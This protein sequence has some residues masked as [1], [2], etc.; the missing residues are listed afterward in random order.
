[1]QLVAAHL[2]PILELLPVHPIPARAEAALSMAARVGIGTECCMLG[3][4]VESEKKVPSVSC[5][6]HCVMMY[7]LCEV[8]ARIMS[9]DTYYCFIRSNSSPAPPTLFRTAAD[10]MP[11]SS[12]HLKI[13]RFF[14]MPPSKHKFCHDCKGTRGKFRNQDT[15]AHRHCKR[16]L[17]RF[18]V[19]G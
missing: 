19:V 9:M 12:P 5:S 7:S 4:R 17:R 14:L 6:D 1:V 8:F 15:T 16:V 11:H 2:H 13:F 3:W 10:T 18:G